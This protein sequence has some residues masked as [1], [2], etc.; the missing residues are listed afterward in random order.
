MFVAN[1]DGFGGSYEEDAPESALLTAADGYRCCLF[2]GPTV[3]VMGV[4]LLWLAASD[5]QRANLRTYNSAVAAWTTPGGGLTQLQAELGGGVSTLVL[6]PDA[7]L[8][9]ASAVSALAPLLASSLPSPPL[10]NA[11]GRAAL[12]PGAS[13]SFV[14]ELPT[15]Y[16]AWPFPADAYSALAQLEQPAGFNAGG[17]SLLLVS[18]SSTQGLQYGVDCS[19]D[20]PPAPAPEAATELFVM[21]RHRR[22]LRQ[23]DMGAAALGMGGVGAS[24]DTWGSAPPALGAKAGRATT[25]RGYYRT[26]TLLTSAQLLAVPPG[27]PDTASGYASPNWTLAL[28]DCGEGRT[29]LNVPVSAA[30]WKADAKAS[31]SGVAPAWCA[32]WTQLVSAEQL[33]AAGA[34]GLNLTLRSADD[35]AV[36]ANALTECSGSLGVSP[37]Q[38]AQRGFVCFVGG[39]AMGLLGFVGSSRAA[40]AEGHAL[41][42]MAPLATLRAWS[43]LGAVLG[44]GPGERVPLLGPRV[45]V[46][47]PQPPPSAMRRR[48]V[49]TGV[50]GPPPGGA[51]G[52]DGVT[53]VE[54]P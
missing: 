17:A 45:V 52:F 46:G 13:L 30:Q 48:G 43:G 2:T 7:G 36:T 8:G 15:L 10:G 16:S 19:A 44:D 18:C 22:R 1:S 50:P 49:A 39:V 27:I 6:E 9:N 34:G 40:A 47:V 21:E 31:V 23:S 14:A 37:G 51:V 20:S 26:I 11:S 24:S 5:P 25:C 42:I 32:G 28:A 4:V 33:E 35:P 29:V 12:Y 38:F 41:G 53:D 3:A 54:A